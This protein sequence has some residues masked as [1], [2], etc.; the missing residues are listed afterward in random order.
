M[1]KIFAK[2]QSSNRPCR[3]FFPNK[4]N[5]NKKL[6]NTN[7]N[8]TEIAIQ[9]YNQENVINTLQT[10]KTEDMST[11]QTIR[12]KQSLFASTRIYSKASV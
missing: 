9:K 1:V 2:A 5:L 12:T 4:T 7:L 11:D 10:V 3:D 6:L 8:K